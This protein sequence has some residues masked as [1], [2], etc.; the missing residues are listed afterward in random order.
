MTAQHLAIP[1]LAFAAFAFTACGGG[2]EPPSTPPPESAPEQVAPTPEPVPEPEAVVTFD[3][4]ILE[5]TMTPVGNEMRFEQTEFTVQPGQIVH[6][7]FNN[8]ADN[9]A[10]SH[11]VVFLRSAD[12]IDAVGQAAMGAAATD[13]VPASR[14]DDIIANTPMSAPGETVEVTFTAPGT[15]GDYPYICTFPGHYATMQGTMHVAG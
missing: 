2:E 4:P 8:T 7:T 9:P 3:G 5:I 1:I 15:V 14:R 12:V 13:Y 6:I 10:M 11:S